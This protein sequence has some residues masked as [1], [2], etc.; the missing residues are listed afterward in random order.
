MTQYVKR[1]PAVFQTVTEKKFFDAT[2]D[3]VLSKKDSEYLAGFLGRRNPGKYNPITDFYIPEPS[4]NRTWWQLEPTAFSRTEDTTKSNVFFYE[5]ILDNIE[6]Y[7]GNTLNQDRLFNTEYYSFGPPINYDMFVN[8]HDYYWIDQRLPVI[9]IT[10][11]L[12]SD[13]IGQPSYTTPN[14]AN[15]ANLT[16]STGMSIILLDDPDYLEPHTVENFGGCEGIQLIPYFTDVTAGS[17]FEF[18][19]WDGILQLSTGRTINNIY[20]DMK[21]WD[22]QYQ[23]AAGDYITIQRGSTN[24]NA[25]SR[26]NKWYHID[27]I[28]AVIAATGM[29]FPQ[30]A[31]RALRPIIQFNANLI[32]YN[33]GTQ[34]NSEIEYGYRDYSENGSPIRLID[35][36]GQFITTLNTTYSMNL[37]D[38]DLVCFFND[39]TEIDINVYPWDTFIFDTN[40]WDEVDFTATVSRFIFRTVVDN[41][42]FV[43]FAPH[44]S[45]YTPVQDGDIV[46]VKEDGPGNSAQAG[47]TW[48]FENNLWQKAFNDKIGLN[49]PPLFQL[50]DHTGVELDDPAKYPLSTFRGNKIF[51]YKVNPVPGA[52]VDPVLRFPIV[53]TGFAQA[54]DIVFQN[55][56]I[57]D[58]YTYESRID[59]DGYYYYKTLDDA[60]LRNSWN[61]YDPC[62]CSDIIPPPPVNCINTSKQRVIDKFVVGYGSQYQFKLSVTPYGYPTSPDLIVIVNGDEVKSISEEP[63]GYSFTVINDRIYVDLTS[64]ITTLLT[65]PQAMDPVVEIQ[66]YT[67]DLLDP[68]YPGYSEIPQSLEANPN[69]LE[70]SEISGSNLLQHFVSIIG[71]QIGF[72]GTAFGGPNNYRDTRQNQ[73]LGQ[74]IL[75]NVSPLLKTMLVSPR[76]DLSF[77]EGIRF[78]TDE[79]SKFKSKYIKIAQQLINQGFNPVQFKNKTIIISEWVEEILKEINISKEFS[80]AFAY[81]Y[82][83]ANG[84]PLSTETLSGP[85]SGTITLSNFVDLTDPKNALYIYE[86]DSSGQETLLLIGQDY[87]IVSTN[88]AIDVEFLNPIPLGSSIYIALYR[89]PIPAYIPSTPSKLGTY[90]VYIPRMEWDATFVTPTWVI[91]GH[92]GSKSI[93]YGNPTDIDYRDQLLL[94][95]EKR[96]YNLIQQKFR[97]EYYLPIRIEY[98]KSN[99][100]R[101]ARYTRDEYLEITNSY[102]NKW[103]AK[104]RAN[105]RANDWDTLNT[106]TPINKLWKLYNYSNAVDTLDQPLNLPGNWKGIYQYLYGTYNPDTRPWEMLGFSSEPSWWR[107]EYGNP[108]LNLEGQEVWPST[109]TGAHNMYS[110]IELGII[111]Q[112]PCAVYDP[113]SETVVPQE[114]WAKP[115]LSSFI[116]VD[117]L[118]ELRP[119]LDVNVPANSLFDIMYSG[120]PY[121]PFDGYDNEWKYGDGAPVEQAWMSSSNYAFAVQEFLFLMKPAEYGEY[122]W[123]TQGTELSPG[124]IN[125]P[126]S[127]TPV[128][129]SINWQFVQNEVYSF[130]DSFFKWM[131]PKNKD[132]VV[133]AESIENII[134]VRFGYQRWI[135]DRILFLG[136]DITSTFGQK[137]RT[138][139]VSLANKFAGFTNKDTTNVYIESIT[140]TSQTNN[141]IIPSNNFEVLLHKSPVV[142][143]YT[144]SGVIIRALADGTFMVYGYDLLSSEFKVFDRSVSK[145]IEISVGGT[146]AEFYQWVSGTTYNAGDIVRYNGVYYLSKVSQAVTKFADGSWNRLKALPTVGGIS[147]SYKPISEPT[148]SRVPYGSIFK[149]IQDVFDFLIGWGAYLES[150]GWKFD[151]VNQDT[152]QISDWLYAGK[153]FL[154]WLNSDWAPDAS[155]QLSPLAN[156]ATLQVAR[157]YPNDVET[158]SNGVY[159]ILDKYGVAISPADTMTDREGQ[160]ISIEPSSLAAGGI[161]FLQVNVSETEHVLIFDNE[162]SFNDTVYSPL[163]RARQQRLRFNGFRSNGWYGKMEAPGYIVMGNELV[164]NYDTIVEAMRYYYDPNVTIDNPSLEDL[165]RHLIGYES[166]SYL[167][168]L[169]VSNDVQYLFYQGAIR[170]KG[171][172]QSLDKLFR[173]TKIQSDENIEIYEEWALKLGDFGNTIEQVSTEFSIIPEQNTGEVIVSRLNY[174]PSP[175]GFVQAIN[176]LNA[177]IS[178]TSVPRIIVGLPDASPNDPML[179]QPIRRAK[180]YAVLN[181]NGTIA[182]IDLTD[183][184]YGYTKPP[185]VTIASIE[186]VGDVDRAYSVWQGEIRRDADLDN[187]IEIDIDNTELWTVRPPEPTHTLKFPVTNN[188]EYPIPNAGYVNFNDV[189]FSSFDV[190]QTVVNWGTLGFNPE[191]ND[192]V[193]VAKTFTEDWDVYKL[194]SIAPE[195]FD[196]VADDNNSL[197]LRTSDNFL[198]TPQFVTTGD[199]N[200]DFG[201]LIILQVTEKQASATANIK[202]PTEQAIAEAFVPIPA[203]AEINSLGGPLNDQILASNITITENGSNYSVPPSVIIEPPIKLR[204]QITAA[205][206]DATGQISSLEIVEPGL[207]YT[208]GTTISIGLPVPITA[209]AEAVV[210]TSTKVVTAISVVEAGQGYY[211]ADPPTITIEDPGERAILQ[212]SISPVTGAISGVTIVNAGAGYIG[213]ETVSVGALPTQNA[214]ASEVY[215]A[216]NGSI[217]SVTVTQS[218]MGY[219]T[220]PPV[221]IGAPAKTQATASASVSNGFVSGISI[222]AAG[223]GYV[224]PPQVLVSPPSKANAS[225]YAAITG[226]AVTSLTLSSGG[227]GYATAPSVSISGGGGSGATASAVVSNGVVTDIVLEN[228]GSNYTSTPSVSIGPPDGVAAT[229]SATISSSYTISSITVTSAGSGYTSTPS[230]IIGSPNAQT[231]TAT[232]SVSGGKV[233]SVTISNPGSGYTMGMGMSIGGPNGSTATLSLTFVDGSVSAVNI[234]N[235]GGGYVSAPPVTVSKPLGQPATATASLLGG[236]VV[237][238]NVTFGGQGYVKIPKVTISPPVVVAATATVTTENG[239]ISGYAIT[240]AGKGYTFNPLVTVPLSNGQTATAITT[241]TGDAVTGITMTDEGSGYSSIPSITIEECQYA[242][243]VTGLPGPYNQ[244]IVTNPGAFFPRLTAPEITIVGDGTGATAIAN[245]DPLK[246]GAITSIDITNPGSG[247]TYADVIIEAPPPSGLGE[248]VSITMDINGAGYDQVPDAWVTDPTIGAGGATLY[249]NIL[250]GSIPGINV[251]TEGTGYEEPT[252]HIGPPTN[253]TPSSNYVVG[254]AF[255]R[256]EDGYN[257]Y[258]LVKL[259]GSDITGEEIDVYEE[260]NKLL[261]FKTMRFWEQPAFGSLPYVEENDKIWVDGVNLSVPNWNVLKVG[262]TD[263]S[264]YR[265]QE[266]LINTHLFKS[267]SIFDTRSTNLLAL[268]PVYDPFKNIMPGPAIQNVSYVGMKDPARYNVTRD[269][270]LFSENI[271]F[272]EEQVGQLWWDT[273]S[274]RYVYYEQPKWKNE[275]GSYGVSNTDNLVY[276]RDNWGS[277]FPGSTIDIYEWTKSSQPPSQYTGTGTPRDINTYVETISINKFTNIPETNYYFWVLN[278]TVVPNSQNRSLAANDVSRLLQSPKSQGFMFFAPIQYTD[279]N[280]SYIFYNVQ[281]IL[282]YRGNNVQIQYRLEERD[283]QPHAQWAFY[284]EGDVSSLIR[285]QFWNKMVDSICGYTKM[286]PVSDEYDNSIL[287]FN[288]IPTAWDMFPWDTTSFGW[289][290]EVPNNGT[291]YGEILPV[292]DP[293]LSDAEKYGIQYRPRQGMF[294]K[295]QAARKVFVQSAN[296]LLQYI[297]IRDD[298]PSWNIGVDTSVY[299]T[300]TNWYKAGYENVEPTISYQTLAMATTALNANQLQVGDIVQVID[301]TLDGRYV[302]YAVVQLNPNIPVLSLEE[303]GVENSAIKLLDTIYTEVNKYGLSVELRQLLNAFRTEVMVN[304]NIVDQ[305]LL[306][307]ALLNYVISEQKAPNWVFKTSY[308]YIKENNVPLTQNQLYVPNQID[309]IIQYIYDAKPYHTQ[310]RDYASRY[311]LADVTDGTAI[312]FHK[313]KTIL[314]FGPKSI[315]WDMGPWDQGL[316]GWD[317]NGIEWIGEDAGNI[318]AKDLIPYLEQLVSGDNDF[319]LSTISV[320][321]TIPD[322]TKVG[323]SDLYPYTFDFNSV[324]INNPQTFITPENIVAVMADNTFLLAGHDFYVEYNSLDSTYTAY[325]FNDPSIYTSLTALVFF[326]GGQLQNI[327]FDTYRNEIA[328]GFA[329]TD[330]VVNVDTKLPVNDVSGEILGI[331]PATFTADYAPLVGWGT[332]SWDEFSDPV[333]SEILINEGGTTI[334]TWDTPINP[335]ILDYTISFKEN[336]SKFDDLG[337]YRNNDA[338]SGVLVTDLPSPTKETENLD[339]LVVSTVSD[340]L[341][342]PDIAVGVVWIDGERIEYRT[343]VEASPGVWELGL[344]V[345]GTKG[346]APTHHYAMVPTV[347]DPM[348]LVPNKV[349]IEQTN[350]MPYDSD[351]TVWQAVDSLPDLSTETIPNEYTSVTSV[352]LGG[353]WYSETNPATFLKNGQGKSIY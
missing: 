130:E 297:P 289:D 33:S 198:I 351:N 90:P 160:R 323:Y 242:N 123:D 304:E 200:T 314:K 307:F 114:V 344:L 186:N 102:L 91:I 129:S 40:L 227:S 279:I 189:D 77:I 312:D 44:T 180:A 331:E 322:P 350:I 71:G 286:L 332:M 305:N 47:E 205:Y 13:I 19:P 251:I 272:A 293:A 69:Q 94:E 254:F 320:E 36:Q 150:K 282:A 341:P 2:F 173:S 263:Y 95:L 327:E 309:N 220:P 229:A 124:L 230:V 318:D 12:A 43:S 202:P 52:T 80:K 141:L 253:F 325:F 291:Y 92:D 210:N 206:N 32:L 85:I 330:M 24:R 179:T 45:W 294:V 67:H 50:Y 48:Y 195:T 326:I 65:T 193:W 333:I 177:E 181:T 192:T 259:D 215:S 317:S 261:I 191:A 151:E 275:D 221:I 18:L 246:S 225:G 243:T 352:P 29:P 158:M 118:G 135:S 235:P 187:I 175:I 337:Y 59:I 171:T 290:L 153:Q 57:V 223:A 178:Y 252:V 96:I 35:F 53:Y 183:Q 224:S 273:S 353:L 64:Y 255:D 21:T 117:A 258:K 61:L 16:L 274:T 17:T 155:I 209:T 79:Y 14:T 321:L 139:D 334:I 269:D 247:Y 103:A 55:N 98:V 51:S 34:F 68:L 214:V 126:D 138:L 167:D 315:G 37:A 169:Q 111:R 8:Y 120:N 89:N 231:A 190:T 73:S 164:P 101:E 4:K 88:L 324:N 300:Y 266:K 58:R 217:S 25:W 140:P 147:V 245:M 122:M 119:I 265:A 127:A 241:L 56:L 142:D 226:D 137:V 196:I 295:L 313:L 7:G 148:I 83:V 292:P 76:G 248:I 72:D 60:V 78:S 20:W 283:D 298:N 284:R 218:G 257:Y 62:E 86:V 41:D 162:T 168:N 240:N 161:Y 174:I 211:P 154:F 335:T 149:T 319:D 115:G 201:N 234:T 347:V 146:P 184:G 280:N 182:R 170:Q 1:L 222:G 93:A 128:R 112:G 38:G 216:A 271:M 81:S 5:D 340:I 30:I 338:R 108:I 70:V 233:S 106:T 74:F 6:Y 212:A 87:E 39:D 336:K 306:F 276:I 144:Y 194:V 99:Y 311:T 228:G 250:N 346:T 63:D 27:T 125:V 260:F 199:A 278:P 75:Q 97:D 49:Q 328:L 343:K 188:I 185:S 238:I 316:V 329:A 281:E 143:T 113:N 9:S 134:Q 42:G 31:T 100:F 301:G 303:V 296:S 213:S 145:L 131:R 176:I 132:Q 172:I 46:I 166:K 156:R 152:N 208:V 285:D 288:D 136:K 308:I 10:G 204:G 15:P 197:Y 23:P 249:A 105:Y 159:S 299:W 26:T 28:K 104:N 237:G 157:G 116:P 239:K 256:E 232:A 109:A 262:A 287:V 11:V 163:L 310:V 268:L 219:A 165:G 302:L 66:T 22:T 349:W 133:H 3:Q 110:D 121:D 277:L 342:N 345:R 339:V 107:F 207:G 54:S 267:A 270:T 82:M 84:S 264:V 244:L 236:R 203:T 348:I